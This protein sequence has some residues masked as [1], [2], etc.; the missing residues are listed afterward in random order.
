MVAVGYDGLVLRQE[1]EL[2]HRMTFDSSAVNVTDVTDGSLGGTA[3][4]ITSWDSIDSNTIKVMCELSGATGVNGSG[5]IAT[6]SFEV[7]GNA[8]DKCVLEIS[9][10]MLGNNEAEE[11]PAVWVADEVTV[12]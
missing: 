5:N 6:I 4:P 2:W 9:D 12:K 10:G 11:I 7:L 8:G 1:G 3:I